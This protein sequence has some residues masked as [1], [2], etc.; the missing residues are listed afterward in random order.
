M[1]KIIQT[2][3]ITVFHPSSIRL[4][5]IS[6][7]AFPQ[8]SFIQV[9]KGVV[10]QYNY[11]NHTLDIFGSLIRQN[12]RLRNNFTQYILYQGNNDSSSSKEN[13]EKDFLAC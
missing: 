7:T 11:L 10:V 12:L 5:E 4:N 1:I 9:I 6:L 3:H 2:K 13:P 8:V